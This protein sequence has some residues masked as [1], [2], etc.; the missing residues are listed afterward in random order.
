MGVVITYMDDTYGCESDGLVP[1][2]DAVVPGAN[3]IQVHGVDHGSSVGLMDKASNF[4]QTFSK[5][6]YKTYDDSPA[7]LTQA[8]ITMVLKQ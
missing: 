1:E 7:D 8:L 5:Q 6:D 4:L 3:L 2:K